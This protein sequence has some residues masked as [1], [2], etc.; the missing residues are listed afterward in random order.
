MIKKKRGVLKKEDCRCNDS[1]YTS[2]FKNSQDAIYVA[3]LS[4]KIIDVNPAGERLVE[5]SRKELIGMHQT[6]LHPSSKKKIYSAMFKNHVLNKNGQEMNADV[7]T[8]SGKLIPVT[9]TASMVEHEG[10]KYIRGNFHDISFLKEIENNLIKEKTWSDRL[11]NE[12]PNIL[13]GFDRNFRIILFNKFAEELTHYKKE[14]VLGKKWPNLFIPKKFKPTIFKVWKKIVSKE[15]IEHHFINS[16]LDKNGQE[17]IIFWSNSVLKEDGKF[18]MVLSIGEDIT[19]KS[20]L[21]GEKKLSEIAL[22]SI[23]D[24]FYFYDMNGKMIF[25]NKAFSKTPGYSDEEIRKKYPMDFYT[26]NDRKKAKVALRKLIAKGELAGEI[27][28]TLKNKKKIPLEFSNQ[29]VRDEQGK[30]VGICG[31]GRDVSERKKTEEILVNSE[32]KYH[33]IIDNS[34]DGIA[35]I[36]KDGKMPL[37]NPALAK[38]VGHSVEEMTNGNFLNFTHP[39]AQKIAITVHK[40]FY[41]G[42]DYFRFDASL[43]HK[44]GHKVM[45]EDFISPVKYNGERAALVIIRDITERKKIEEELARYRFLVEQSNQQVALADMSG[46]IV[47][48]NCSW[49]NNHGYKKK[50]II[51]KHLSIFHTKEEL[52]TVKKFNQ[53]L[54]K[55]GRYNGEIVHKRKDGSTYP[56]WM[57]NFVLEI[58]SKKYMVGMATNVSEL[59]K[60][61]ERYRALIDTTNTG[62][63]ILDE[64]GRVLDANSEYV[65]LTGYHR[66]SEIKGKSV[67]NWTAKWDLRKNVQEIKKCFKKGFVRNLEVDYVDKKGKI[68]PIEINATVIRSE[69]GST[70]VTL[71]RDISERRKAEEELRK[72]KKDVERRVEERTKE[73]EEARQKYLNLYYS[74]GDA[75]MT[76]SPPTWKF[77]SGN[78]ATLRMFNILNEKKFVSL[79]PW[80]LSPKYQPDGQLSDKKAPKMIETAMKKGN[81]FFE[82]THL[83]YK[84]GEFPATVL[85]SKVEDG[86]K[87]YLQATV[88]D[89]TKEKKAE[90][91][92]LQQKGFLNSVVENIPHMIFVKEAKEL[93]FE[94]FNKAGEELLGQKRENLIG[95]NDYDFFPKSQAKFFIKKDREVLNKKVLLDIPEEPI[96]T[97]QGE[98]ILHT[99]KIPILDENNN[100]AYLLGISEDITPEK[101]AQE[102]IKAEEKKYRDLVENSGAN[103][104]LVNR[105]G[106]F[107]FV[108]ENAAKELGKTKDQVV[109]KTMWQLFPK[110]HADRQMQSI[111]K[112]MQ[113]KQ[114]SESESPTKVNNHI[115]WYN[116]RLI[117]LEDKSGAV[118]VVQGISVDITARKGAEQELIKSKDKLAEKIAELERFTKIAVGRELKMVE[119]KKKISRLEEKNAVD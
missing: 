89:I 73:L 77:N 20:K 29:V 3:D 5:R 66:L 15:M 9:I 97:P 112:V 37:V 72:S 118:N 33:T 76:L 22:A 47:F 91:E 50:D 101:I 45:I 116:T 92:M 14:E 18:K 39:D 111:L 32:E 34:G 115:L 23:K 98:R 60:A 12:A 21:E 104:F 84:G 35:I 109:G 75:I 40:K 1:F 108:N 31:V 54:L 42:K 2:L 27:D 107:L 78:P 25:W 6:K 30:S 93:R 119:L 67:L 83:R 106:E 69:Q 13:V 7:I 56:T 102:K 87:T 90:S 10:K 55:K 64:K 85:L 94:R 71:C 79:G 65:R 100:P 51:G 8:K 44:D 52:S 24:L 113:T 74:S 53:E 4:G 103:I 105:K 80:Q 81:N 17:R 58:G 82:W 49:A 117:P 70:I 48:V 63:L 11:V 88:R 59:K 57:D 61:E 110:E 38:M 68:T 19:E 28:I 43:I 41:S 96:K 26:G 114:L 36:L 95:K 99:R 62:Y 86:G 16:I 46:K